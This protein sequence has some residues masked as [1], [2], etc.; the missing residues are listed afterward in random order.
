MANVFSKTHPFIIELL[1][2]ALTLPFV[3]SGCGEKLSKITLRLE[4]GVTS[5][6]PGASYNLQVETNL[7]EYVENVEYDV[8]Q[9]SEYVSIVGNTLTVLASAVPESQISIVAVYNTIRSSALNLCVQHLEASSLQISSDSSDVVAGE[10]VT[11]SATYFPANATRDVEYQVLTDNATVINNFAIIDSDL[12]QGN[13][14]RIQAKMGEVLSNVLEFNVIEFNADSVVG[15]AFANNNLVNNSL[16]IDTSV[17]TNNVTL[18]AQLYLNLNGRIA[19]VVHSDIEYEVADDGIISYNSS[20]FSVSP[21]MKGETQVTA[22]YLD[23]SATVN[24]I[25][26]MVPLVIDLPNKFRQS[27]VQ[28]NYA[29]GLDISGFEPTY[30]QQNG[31]TDYALN[32]YSLD[33]LVARFEV[34]GDVVTADTNNPNIA[35]D[36]KTLNVNELANYSFSFQSISGCQNEVESDR[37]NIN[38]NDGTNV[39]NKAEFFSAIEN[40]NVKKINFVNDITLEGGKET[41]TSHGDKEINGNS[42]RLDASKQILGVNEYDPELPLL[43]FYSVDDNTPYAVTIRDLSIIGNFGYLSTAELLEIAKKVEPN[44]TEQDLIDNKDTN[45]FYSMTYR[46]AIRVHN[47]TVDNPDGNTSY[48]YCKLNLKNLNISNFMTGIKL[49]YVMDERALTGSGA[50]AIQ[51]IS[52]GNLFGDGITFVGSQLTIDGFNCGIVGG[53][54]LALNGPSH[55]KHAGPYRNLEAYTRLT[56]NVRIDNNTDGSGIYLKYQMTNNEAV[57]AI[58]DLMKEGVSSM[59]NTIVSLIVTQTKQDYRDDKEMI[60]KINSTITN[61][62]T[63]ADINSSKRNLFNLLY[64]NAADAGKF[65]IDVQDSIVE[66]SK[67]FCLNGVDTT[68]QFIEI[69]LYD[70]L[71]LV[72]AFSSIVSQLGDTL[73]PIEVIIL[74]Q[75]YSVA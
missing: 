24:I 11:L 40:V 9:G 37:V 12:N 53:S 18:L 14:V 22:K 70:T 73:K 34:V 13:T 62:F 28:Y 68:H 41:Y 27:G 52:L 38:F 58:Y 17:Q 15:V 8:R 74:N 19:K 16:M 55:A 43:D 30:V 59:I 2:V 72:P 4:D 32:V 26:N 47:A 20:S 60:N 66:F 46:C 63:E 6:V 69:S 35:Y 10:I 36:G 21:L 49:D 54:P 45:Y 48:S 1:V 25:V 71:S 65:I 50:P 75:N 67:D 39:G 44:I 64:F 61:I 3:F 33:N 5:V 23:K 57:A 31:C 29:K 42:F 7:D 51:N 56:G